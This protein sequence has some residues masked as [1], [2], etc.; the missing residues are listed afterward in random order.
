MS[1]SR[2]ISSRFPKSARLLKRV[3]FLRVQGQ[4]RKVHGKYI[5]LS[6]YPTPR[7]AS[8]VVEGGSQPQAD[9]SSS[10]PSSFKSDN[11]FSKG[12]GARA[13]EAQRE[14]VTSR[15]GFTISK[16]TLK[17]SVKRNKVRRRLREAVRLARPN[18][19]SGFDVVLVAKQESDG[20][21]FRD[22]D[23]ELKLL[24]EKARLWCADFKKPA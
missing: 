10:K 19:R 17:S 16:K 9:L 14:A 1:D 12:R 24:L 7:D 11:S 3:D 5:W 2:Y 18:I 15:F 8:E 20:V 22:L 6:A 23:K 13:E 21:G 4:G